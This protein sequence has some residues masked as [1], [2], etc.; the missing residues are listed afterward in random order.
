MKQE[1]RRTSLSLHA[2]L[3]AR[4]D[5]V[6]DGLKVVRPHALLRKAA[7]LREAIGLGLRELERE[8]D[9]H[10]RDRRAP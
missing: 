4:L 5:R 2:A 9:E 6:V 7:V 8:I 1:A 3:A 10:R